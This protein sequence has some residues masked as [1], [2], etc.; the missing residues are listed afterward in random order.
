VRTR[1]V[2]FL[3]SLIAAALLLEIGL[4]VSGYRSVAT[5][6]ER[7]TFALRPSAV[8]DLHYDLQPGAE[9]RLWQC[10]VKI[11]SHGFRDR[12]YAIEK[13]PGTTRIVALGDSITFGNYLPLET[14]WTERLEALYAKRGRPVEVLN[15]GVGGYDSW[16]EVRFLEQVGLQFQPD[17]VFLCYCINDV[18]TVSANL[19]T[20]G[21]AERLPS[22]LRS[23]HAAQWLT[24]KLD[25]GALEQRARARREAEV[26]AL[27]AL[28]VTEDPVL[29]AL[30]HELEQFAAS[31]PGSGKELQRDITSWIQLEWYL[32]PSRLERVRLAFQH[33]AELSAEHA[34]GV[35]FFLVPH[36]DEGADGSMAGAWEVAYRMVE[37]LAHACGF[38]IVNVRADLTGAGLASL[39]ARRTDFVHP[40]R[41]GHEIIARALRRGVQDLH[42]LE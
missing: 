38:E 10:D 24:E 11:N 6:I 37:H 17:W 16:Q 33:L 20:L 5:S 2:V 41:T 35:V 13:A 29:E 4:R 39:R 28:P 32:V 23:L 18:A 36:L 40:G 8:P 30:R 7:R 12:E 42:G 21:G 9:G 1:L 3:A 27:E 14:V 19:E 22:W 15:L 31:K 34:F 26:R 25:A